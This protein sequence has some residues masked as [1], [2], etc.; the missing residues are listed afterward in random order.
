M[1]RHDDE[2]WRDGAMSQNLGCPQKNGIVLQHSVSIGSLV[3]AFVD[4]FL[5]M[6]SFLSFDSLILCM[7]SC[8][9]L[10]CGQPIELFKTIFIVDGLYTFLL[11]ILR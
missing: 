8:Q 4:Y 7:F 2:V 10:S 3:V 11:C 6:I 5:G 1:S 9:D